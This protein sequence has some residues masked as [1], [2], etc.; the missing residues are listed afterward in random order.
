MAEFSGFTCWSPDVV[1]TTIATEAVTPSTN[2]FLATHAPLAITQ[3]SSAPRG[4]ARRDASEHDVLKDL[5]DRETNNG[6][7]VIP[8]LGDS[9]AGKSHLVRWI[10]EHLE[11]DAG[12]RVIYLRKDQTNLAGVIN[13][14]LIDLEGPKYDEIRRNVA[15][16]GQEVT[17]ETLENRLLNELAEALREVP[18]SSVEERALLGENHLYAL[19][20]DPHFRSVLLRAG[21]LI[22]RRAIHIIEGRTISESDVPLTF[23]V[24]D[25]PH[26]IRDESKAGDAARRMYGALVAQ[27]RLQGAAVDL[28]NRH[29]DIAV[30]QATALGV[31]R[32]QEAFIDI[33]RELAG[34]QEIVLLVEDFALIQGVQRDILDAIVETG[35]RDGRAELA[36]IRTLMAVTSGYYVGKLDETARTRIEASSPY[37]YELGATFEAH[38]DRVGVED[39][40]VVD[41]LGR[42]LNA[43]RLGRDVL[44]A[45][46][47][48]GGEIPNACSGC[49]FR[50]RCHSGFDQ[51]N[52][53]Y[54]L[55]PF[56]KPALLRAVRASAPLENPD[57]FNP[58][59]ALSRVVYHALS[60]YAPS[61]QR[62][63]F[64]DDA[65]GGDFP[66]ESTSLGLI[67]PAVS[68]Q[69]E[70]MDPT[71]AVRR[72]TLLN[73][74][75][76]APH[77]L[78]N[79]HPAVHEAFQINMLAG[80]EEWTPAIVD[81]AGKVPTDSGSKSGPTLSPALLSR[82]NAI[83]KWFT[84][85]QPLEEALARELRTAIVDA[86][87]AKLTWI[88]PPMRQPS[89]Q[90]VKRGLPKNST[91]VSIEGARGEERVAKGT[92]PL[93]R[94]ERNAQN[95]NFFEAL[96]KLSEGLPEGNEAARFRLD[97]VSENIAIEAQQRVIA[98]NE[99]RDEDVL[100]AL[101]VSLLGAA[102]CGQL[103]DSPKLLDLLNAG[104]WLPSEASTRHDRDWR[105]NRWLTLEER[106]LKYRH[107]LVSTLKQVCGV[108]QGT[109]EVHAI[110]AA[111]VIPMLR[112]VQGNWM[113]PPDQAELPSWAKE[114]AAPLRNVA[115]L[116]DEELEHQA[117]TLASIRSRL[118]SGVSFQETVTAIERAVNAGSNVGFVRHTNLPALKAS[119]SAAKSLDSR[120]ID[121]YESELA[122]HAD[123]GSSSRMTV[124]ARDRGDTLT[125]I[126][127]FLKAS[128]EWLDRSLEETQEKSSDESVR[129]A[130]DVSAVL[131]DWEALVEGGE[132]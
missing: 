89:S 60:E 82:I 86:L 125:R 51:S 14:L 70:Q 22:N 38:G 4:S 64:P 5:I 39:S 54:G 127:S 80:L 113:A 74:W 73:Y 117:E 2:V 6:V 129:M 88:D 45:V 13:S 128:E 42:Y 108:A 40:V 16:L 107:N 83:T 9:G 69:L 7:L 3:V 34:K 11:A 32:L 61:I 81:P 30:M 115:R 53:G 41:F 93:I 96:I 105:T 106:H 76:D 98:I 102:I 48:R 112:S 111:R 44:D 71:S 58:R 50:D 97:Q 66:L 110:D 79:L 28:L 67:S 17:R 47:V 56:N 68:G 126:D 29:L 130:E 132:K 52:Q 91:T 124:A 55:Y 87:T 62:G 57:S 122:K 1:R 103:S 94:F 25:L 20:H 121:R 65:F 35:V 85:K 37:R 15:R 84:H 24:E 49:V 12:R 95:A 23:T 92:V 120:G 10:H 63:E 78:V 123:A 104:F 33:R 131:R 114:A 31:G 90:D 116:V 36:P 75:G 26:D 72:S 43:A 59:S 21:G 99:W 46:D 119:I 118:P 101:R 27:P 18:P 19:M 109:G 100:L 77:S 8:V